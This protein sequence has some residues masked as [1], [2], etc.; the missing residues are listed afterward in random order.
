MNWK[1]YDRDIL[2]FAEEGDEGDSDEPAGGGPEPD[3][4][5]SDI[6]KLRSQ[7]DSEMAALRK[8]L[9]ELKDA[10]GTDDYQSQTDREYAAAQSYVNTLVKKLDEEKDPAKAVLLAKQLLQNDIGRNYGLAYAQSKVNDTKLR[11]AQ[12]ERY[13]IELTGEFGGSVASHKAQLLEAK[14]E[15]DMRASFLELRL[16]LGKE[17]KPKGSKSD[18]TESRPRIDRGGGGAARTNILSEME[19]IDLS[20][21]EGQKKWQEKRGEF[22]RKLDAVSR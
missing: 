22:R 18:S 5:E 2:M 7:Y 4:E 13:A 19:D 12:A 20:T 9:K 8:E 15:A 11:N 21:P 3:S 10:K 17:K 6:D 14:T 1:M 16:S